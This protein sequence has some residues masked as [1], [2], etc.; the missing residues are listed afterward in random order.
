MAVFGALIGVIFT[1][2]ATYF[3]DASPLKDRAALTKARRATRRLDEL[4]TI[5]RYHKDRAALN[6]YLLSRVLVVITLWAFGV[7]VDALVGLFFSG[8]SGWLTFTQEPKVLTSPAE[9]LQQAKQAAVYAKWGSAIDFGTNVFFVVVLVF[10]VRAGLAARRLW[11][12]TEQYDG[13]QDQIETTILELEAS[14]SA[15]KFGGHKKRQ[16]AVG[17]IRSHDNRDQD[18]SGHRGDAQ[19]GD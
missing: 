10:T 12:Q 11:R 16:E 15:D 5:Q 3:Y 19:S 2:I 14:I 9:M 4:K 18:Q 17:N 6:S 7:A 1:T 13:L 8:R